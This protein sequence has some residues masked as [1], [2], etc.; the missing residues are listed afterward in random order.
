MSHDGLNQDQSTE[1][2]KTLTKKK[3]NN[4][5]A[6]WCYTTVLQQLGFDQYNVKPI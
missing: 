1:G 2:K 6:I 3:N 5:S 4:C